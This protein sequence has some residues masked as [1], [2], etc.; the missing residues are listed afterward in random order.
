MEG[1]SLLYGGDAGTGLVAVEHVQH[2]G[3][4]DEMELFLRR[5]QDTAREREPFR[6]YLW[7]KDG[8]LDGCPVEHEVRPLSGDGAL[9]VCASFSSWKDALKARSW[10]RSE[11]GFNSGAPEAPYLFLGDPVQQFLLSS[12]RTLFYGMEFGALRRMQVDIECLT[13]EGYDFCNAEREGD[14]IVAIAMSD[15]DGWVEVISGSEAEEK[16]LLERFVSLLVERDPDVIEGHNLF[17][18]DLPYLAER[19]KRHRVKLCIGRDGSRPSRRSSR[20]SLGDRTIAYERFDIFGRHVV[21]TLFL[22]HAYDIAHRSLDGLGLKDVAAHFGVAA[23]DRTYVDGAKIT[24]TFREDP[25]RLLRYVRDDAMETRAVSDI[26]SKSYFFQAQM[27]PYSYQAV[28]VRGNATKIDA[29]MLRAYLAAGRAV[30]MPDRPREFA[31]GYTDVFV[32]GIVRDVHH[33]DIRSLYPSL[34]L[35]QGIKPG[36]DELDVFLGMLRALRD[37]RV[38]AKTKMQQCEAALEKADYE[39]LQSTFKILINSFYGYLGFSQARF[40]DFDAAEKVASEGRRL[41]EVMIRWLKKHGATPVEIDTDGIYFVPPEFK[42]KGEAGRIEA[43]RDEFASSL[44]EGIEI[45]FDG[46]YRSMFSYKMKNYAL[47]TN[48]GELLIKGAALRSR[49]IEP[50]QRAFLRE[51]LRLRLEEKEKKVPALMARYRKE[52]TEAAWPVEH[53]ARTERLQDAPATYAAKIRGSKRPRS[54]AYELALNS[55]REY[56]AGDQVAYYVT[57]NK[58]SVA[59]HEYAKLVGEWDPDNRDE[60]V[61]YY[62]AKLEALY[63]KFA[64]AEPEQ[65]NLNLDA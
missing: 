57:G 33:C 39:S 47:L 15:Q 61:P 49:G 17:N 6:P 22:S 8:V 29:L 62:L 54:A 3:K 60:N 4:P 40:S 41:L 53:F 13:S 34:M 36:T 27:L 58:K 14:A 38:D 46:E 52:L 1:D 18:F 12:G 43:F 35:T 50:F 55:G 51:L 11:T 44:P 21:D 45:E 7:V 24:E 25:D 5:G 30:P 59:V 16:D 28:C 10:L 56:R 64:D 20:V 37:F 42:G 19:A 2:R 63:K 31:G 9:S 26:L 48:D 32:Q 65:R 23:P